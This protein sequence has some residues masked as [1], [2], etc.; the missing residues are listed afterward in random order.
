MLLL[1]SSS[2][3]M[4]R[5]SRHVAVVQSV[6]Q[7]RATPPAHCHSHLYHTHTLTPV[8]HTHTPVLLNVTHTCITYTHLYYSLSLTPVSHTHTHTHTHTPVLLT[9]THTCI[10]HTHTCITHCHSHLY[11]THTHTCITQCTKVLGKL[12]TPIVHQ[13]AKLVAAPFLLSEYLS[14]HINSRWVLT[15]HS[16]HAPTR[17]LNIRTYKPIYVCARVVQLTRELYYTLSKITT[18]T[19]IV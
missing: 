16:R 8:S 13:A 17:N 5:V 9:V 4:S 2:R 10:T 18:D 15:A 14:K 6:L 7:C 11:H 1:T 3:Q 19:H 12:F